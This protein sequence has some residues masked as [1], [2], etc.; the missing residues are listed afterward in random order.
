[1]KRIFFL[2]NKL[3]E[4]DFGSLLKKYLSGYYIAIGEYFPEHP[5]DYDLIVLWSY[6]KKVS[7]LGKK[8]K[9]IL[10]HS[11]NLPEGR[12]WAPIYNSIAQGLGS[13]TISG[14]LA[15]EDIDAGDIIVKAHFALK[16][17]YTAA[18]L[19]KWDT[20]ISIMLTAQILIRFGNEPLRGRKQDSIPTFWPRRTPESNELDISLPFAQLIPHLRACEIQHPA[21]FWLNE[22]KY[23]VYVEPEELPC[24]PEDL[25]INFLDI[26][27]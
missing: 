11:S 7:G 27:Q 21:F 2:L 25:E 24:F 18:V 26:S 3:S 20:E 6:R 19:R 22:T 13:Y 10:F 16:D 12:G 4:F 23:L 8:N 17:N 14:M 15:S 5:D 9:V 1:M